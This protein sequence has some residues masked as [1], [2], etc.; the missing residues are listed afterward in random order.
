[1]ACDGAWCGRVR[2]AGRRPPASSPPRALSDGPGKSHYAPVA[3]PSRRLSYVYKMPVLPLIFDTTLVLGATKLPPTCL[4]PFSHLRGCFETLAA[5]VT[6]PPFWA[7]NFHR[8]A[9]NGCA[10]VHPCVGVSPTIRNE[11]TK[12][13]D[14]RMNNGRA[15][16]FPKGGESLGGKTKFSPR[17]VRDRP[18]RHGDQNPASMSRP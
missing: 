3:Q 12:G 11:N 14:P 2:D 13:R 6:F 18:H 16:I 4:Y 15:T 9:K 5:V 8:H 17:T 10:I 1:M 7:G